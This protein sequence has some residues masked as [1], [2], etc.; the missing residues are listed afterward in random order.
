[1]NLEFNSFNNSIKLFN[2][3]KLKDIMFSIYALKFLK[4][5]SFCYIFC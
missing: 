2:L 3:N 5:K 1:M 4:A